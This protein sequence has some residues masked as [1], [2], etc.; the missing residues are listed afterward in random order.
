MLEFGGQVNKRF[1]ERPDS[2]WHKG[3]DN[4][5]EKLHPVVGQGS[6]KDSQDK[7]GLLFFPLG[8]F[9]E[10][11]HTSLLLKI[12]YYEEKMQR[13]FFELGLI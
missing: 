10:V 12:L 13:G 6:P 1:K 9:P 3:S 2:E 4:L 8:C 5:R 11:E 7:N